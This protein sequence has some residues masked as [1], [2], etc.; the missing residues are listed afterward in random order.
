[1]LR[2]ALLHEARRLVMLC[3]DAG[4]AAAFAIERADKLLE[5]AYM[6]IDMCKDMCANMSADGR[7]CGTL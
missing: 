1:M 5:R 6:C 4:D 3:L 2:P 7:A